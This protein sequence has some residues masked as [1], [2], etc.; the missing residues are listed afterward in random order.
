M[1]WPE[2]VWQRPARA[3]RPVTDRPPPAEATRLAHAVSAG[4]GRDADL[5]Q[6]DTWLERDVLVLPGDSDTLARARAFA[7]AGHP[8]LPTVLRV[9]R[10]ARAVWVQ[11]P[12]G[13]ALADEPRGLSPGQVARLR[14]ALTALRAAG[15][16]HG[17]VDAAH[18]YILDGEVTLAYPRSAPAADAAERDREALVRLTDPSAAE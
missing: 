6:H 5:R 16:A 9:D 7:R 17:L 13:R 4:D 10:E 15:G 3:A 12:L 14:D 1:R 2:R 8:A 11:A 18:L